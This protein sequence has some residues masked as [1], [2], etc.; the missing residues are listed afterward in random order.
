AWVAAALGAL[1][2]TRD[3]PNFLNSIAKPLLVFLGICI[4]L[5]IGEVAVRVKLHYFNRAVLKYPPGKYEFDYTRWHILGVSPKVTFTVNAMGL[6]GP[7]PP[8]GGE[9][10]KVITVG[11]STTECMS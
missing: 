10:Y 1:L 2:L 7:M 8:Q 6:R 9:V 3:R 11:G 5:A 4:A